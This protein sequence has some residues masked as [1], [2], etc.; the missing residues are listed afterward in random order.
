MA[1]I[2]RTGLDFAASRTM[3]KTPANDDPLGR[4]AAAVEALDI[5]QRA[6]AER[7]RLGF[8]LTAEQVAAEA[9]AREALVR[10]RQEALSIFAG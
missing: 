4:Y 5:L 3:A 10:A 8:T 2:R 7:I 1:P 6:N 9:R